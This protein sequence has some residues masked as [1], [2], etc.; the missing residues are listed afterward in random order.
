[1]K[2]QEIVKFS[3]RES[4]SIAIGNDDLPSLAYLYPRLGNRDQH[5]DP[6]A[7]NGLVFSLRGDFVGQLFSPDQQQ[8]SLLAEPTF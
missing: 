6:F 7:S 1:L 8:L 4:C 2:R 3:W 5:A